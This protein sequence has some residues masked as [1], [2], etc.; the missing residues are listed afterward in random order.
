[1]NYKESL[2]S[3]KYRLKGA[4]FILSITNGKVVPLHGNAPVQFMYDLSD[5]AKQYVNDKGY[6]YA[7]KKENNKKILSSKSIPNTL[8]QQIRNVWTFHQ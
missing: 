8:A 3:W 6:V 2:H 4:I 7:V 5:L 1:M